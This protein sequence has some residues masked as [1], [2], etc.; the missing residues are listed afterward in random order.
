[1]DATNRLSNQTIRSGAPMGSADMNN[2][3][4]DDIIRLDQAQTLYIAFQASNGNF[5]NYLVTSFPNSQWSVCV[6]DA[7]RNNF[8]DIFTG[9]SYNGLKLA[10]ADNAGAT[11]SMVSIPS[12][13]VFLQ[14]SN[15]ADI[16]R[17]GLP[18]I[19]ACHDDGL[20]IP[21][22]NLG[23]ANFTTDFNLI[24]PV[25]TVPS[26]NSGNYGSVWMDYNNDG[27]LDLYISK[28]RAGVTNPLDGRRLNLLFRNN[29]NGTFSE[30]AEAAGLRP[31]AQSWAADFADIDNDGD[32]DCFLITHDTPS[33]LFL[34]NGSGVFSNISVQSGM[35][36]ALNATGPGLQ[37]KFEDF[38]ND[39]F[40]DLLY[41]AISGTHWLFRN[42]GNRTFTAISNTPF[43]TG[44]ARIH[45]ATVG[46]FDN[47]GYMDVYA[48]F[49]SGYNSPGTIPDKLFLNQQTGRNF[50][51]VRVKGV[52][53]NP[54][55]IGA[56]IEI[57]GQWGRQIREVR[58]GE[59][60]GIMSSFTKHFGINNAT[61]ID[62][63]IVRWPS[64]IVDRILNPAVN[65]TIQVLEGAHCILDAGFSFTSTGNTVNFLD[66]STLGANQW[67]WNFGNGQ[68][69]TQQNPV[70]TFA[71]PGIYLVC[72]TATGSCGQ[73]TR[74]ISVNVNCSAPVSNFSNA[75]S[76]GLTVQFNDLSTNQ[77]TQWL[78]N[79]GNGQT[80]TQQN[81]LITF[82]Q[83][84]TYEVCLTASGFCGSGPQFCRNVTVSCAAPSSLFLAQTNQLSVALTD[85]SSGNPTQWN[86]NFGNG[87]TSSQQ[88][89]LVT[90]SAPGT[91]RICLI[92]SSVCGMGN[93]ICQDI[94]VGCA[95][96]TSAFVFQPDGLTL[97]LT[98]QSTGNPNQ[99]NWTFSNGQSST[100]Q[101]PEI[102]FTQP[103]T[104]EICLQ[105]TSACGQSIPVCQSV[106][107]SCA[108][109][110]S[111]FI[112]Q[113]DGLV[114][115]LTDQ[116][117]GNPNQW[118]WTF[119]NGLN[120]NQQN[121]E[122]TFAEPGTYQVCLIASS[123]CGMGSQICQ[124]ITVSCTA[125]FSSFIF[126][127]DGLTVQLTDQSTGNPSQWNWTF[128]NGQ[129]SSQQNPEI[130]LAQPGT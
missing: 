124:D 18:D 81:P 20:S 21:L 84:G 46:D 125:P 53:S 26:D 48:G 75:A 39:G 29:G 68:T 14:G 102:T 32:L 77:P 115:R 66:R 16:N 108:T 113:T 28:C 17:D 67:F 11:Y 101:N 80:S 74:C 107:L 126:L 104:Y 59:S 41:T 45:S 123:I 116:S 54:N 69:S 15:F 62:S 98:D 13:P 33:R 31:L 129:S 9:G 49:G 58:S 87:Q 8:N 91:F 93:Q 100:L 43:P 122:I 51:K 60:Y 5:T 25:S 85:L 120:A 82:P 3:G 35:T 6:A 90:Y 34:N 114:V 23:N 24:N 109:P 2:D 37:A 117:T 30:V 70:V 1:M 127:T 47:N 42:N 61:Q 97:Q 63:L 64:G 55:G 44:G 73:A 19:F 72:L 52:V 105:T 12:S 118:S 83:P 65:Q 57:H 56:R 89:P 96:P 27:F 103:G 76:T 40:V 4:L 106:T 79:F 119:G 92:S 121:P 36:P 94:T 38:D 7:D 78:W 22:R 128:S 95:A 10:R 71:N 88:N 86:W 111:N 99:W 112:F 110:F 130:T 50:L